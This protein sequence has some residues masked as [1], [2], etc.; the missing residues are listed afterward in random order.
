M[1]SVLALLKNK[2]ELGFW[3][4]TNVDPQLSG[5]STLDPRC[6][7]PRTECNA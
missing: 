3:R 5:S 1:Y 2:I 4:F 7:Q 6:R